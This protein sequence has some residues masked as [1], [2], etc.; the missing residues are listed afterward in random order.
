MKD[1]YVLNIEAVKIPHIPSEV[2]LLCLQDLKSHI[3]V[4]GYKFPIPKRYF[5]VATFSPLPSIDPNAPKARSQ[6]GKGARRRFSN[7]KGIY[8]GADKGS[9]IN[10]L[11]TLINND[12]KT[13]ELLGM[14]KKM[15]LELA[16][17]ALLLDDTEYI[18]VLKHIEDIENGLIRP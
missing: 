7:Q 15:L 14:S 4:E 17:L 6:G 11:R 8:S 10:K 13:A 12:Y 18:T 5:E 16:N 9:A 2:P 3:V 1:K